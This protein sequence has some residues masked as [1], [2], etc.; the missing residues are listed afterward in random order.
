MATSCI[1]WTPESSD[2]TQNKLQRLSKMC[3]EQV[4]VIG[5]NAPTHENLNKSNTINT[6]Y[7]HKYK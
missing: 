1:T 7:M 5:C 4:A 3:I 6:M 2:L